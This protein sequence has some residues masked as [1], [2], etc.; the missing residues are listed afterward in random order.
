M[1]LVLHSAVFSIAALFTITVCE[2]YAFGQPATEAAGSGHEM[3]GQDLWNLTENKVF[4]GQIHKIFIKMNQA[5][6][7]QLHDD[8]KNHNCEKS[9]D[10]KWGHAREFVFDGIVMENVAMRV[11]G[12]TSRCIP[13]LQ[14]S[15][16]FDKTRNVQTKQ[17]S[18]GWREVQYNDATKAVIQDRTL[19]GLQELSLRRSFN[20]SSSQ[21]DS[22]N[23]MLAREFVATWAAAGAEKVAKTTVRGAPVYRTAYTTV[24]FQLCANDADRTCENRFSRAYLIAE[25]FDNNFFKMRYD[26]SKPTVFSMVHGCALKGDKG[27]EP[28]CTEPE[29]LK[30]KK[31]DKDDAEQNSQLAAFITGPKGLKTQI[32]AAKTA[33]E[34]G[35]VLDLDSIMNYAA[36]ATTV[37]HWDSAYGNFNND[38][39][40]FHAPSGKWKL[41]T[42]DLDNT[43]DFDSPGKPSRSYS[44]REVANAPRLLFDKLF[45]NPELDGQFKKR[46]ADYLGTIYDANGNGPLNDKI[47][48]AR[49][50][51][52]KKINDQ[53]VNGERQDLQRAQEM[54]DY[55]KDR[56]KSL[57]TQLQAN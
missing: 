4:N 26:D 24:E 3:S 19:N 44:Y 43:F 15:V 11:R 30:G 40:Y 46:L 38:I 36:V 5:V 56:F 17:G 35:K 25:T 23:G 7:N 18:E 55:T 34:L 27:L 39:L 52:I 37:G 2:S 53:L 28:R 9:D 51:Y 6:W 32:D 8:E 22:G 1:R 21:N 10:V 48:E 49:D 29:Y 47:I 42:W 41:L 20:D 12:N 50:G 54:F 33:A 14:F 31:Y 16:A 45:A 57:K 13:R